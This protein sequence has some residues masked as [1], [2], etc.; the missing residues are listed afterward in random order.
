MYEVMGSIKAA[1]KKFRRARKVKH[2]IL[3]DKAAARVKCA[4][5]GKVLNDFSGID[6]DGKVMHPVGYRSNRAEYH[7]ATKNVTAMHY[8]CSWGAIMDTVVNMKAA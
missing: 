2:F 4:C 6:Q 3:S 7:P 1:T 5:C 8:I